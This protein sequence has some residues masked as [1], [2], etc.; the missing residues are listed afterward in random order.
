M[1]MSNEESSERSKIPIQLRTHTTA[2]FV[3]VVSYVNGSSNSL[4]NVI[5]DSDIF[6]FWCISFICLVIIR[7]IIRLIHPTVESNFES[8]SNVPFNTAGLFFATT[9][10]GS[11]CSRSELILVTFIAIGSIFTGTLCS[12]I[13]LQSFVSD[14]SVPFYNS[15]LDLEKIPHLQY[16]TN[17]FVNTDNLMDGVRY[18][19]L[20]ISSK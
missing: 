1:M 7:L 19:I 3:T 10:S 18:E 6:N 15:M 4:G 11:V 8:L 2:D 12:G 16:K 5:M 13:L 14:N 9:S 17:T 20:D